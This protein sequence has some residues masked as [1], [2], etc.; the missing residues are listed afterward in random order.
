MYILLYPVYVT[1]RNRVYIGHIERIKHISSQPFLGVTHC[2]ML[3]EAVISGEK[4][5]EISVYRA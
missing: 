3:C 5:H 2:I 1:P 4:S